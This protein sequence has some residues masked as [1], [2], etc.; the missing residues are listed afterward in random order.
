MSLRVFIRVNRKP[1]V[2]ILIAIV[3][4]T[5]YLLSSPTDLTKITVRNSFVNVTDVNNIPSGIIK[6]LDELDNQGHLL[7]GAYLFTFGKVE[8][9]KCSYLVICGEKRFKDKYHVQ[10]T[11]LKTRLRKIGYSNTES[12]TYEINIKESDI[13]SSGIYQYSYPVTVFVAKKSFNYDESL[14]SVKNE[15]GRLLSTKSLRA[16]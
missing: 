4:L 13:I 15:L 14:T 7:P 9:D 8:A 2:V 6:R 5:L 1:I 11:D 12:V 10:I 3:V 16:N